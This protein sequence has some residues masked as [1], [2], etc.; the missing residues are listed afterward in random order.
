MGGVLVLTGQTA[1]AGHVGIEDRSEFARKAVFGHWRRSAGRFD[2]TI[3]LQTLPDSG[4]DT[5]RISTF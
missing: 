4:I 5:P 1:V 2:S 3:V